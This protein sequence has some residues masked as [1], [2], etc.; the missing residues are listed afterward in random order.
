M[1][2]EYTEANIRD[3]RGLLQA[4]AITILKINDSRYWY[5]NKFFCSNG[6]RPI[7]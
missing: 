5:P 7:K 6:C 2:Q 4:V 3:K 1:V